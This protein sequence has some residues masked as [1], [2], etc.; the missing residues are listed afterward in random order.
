MATQ[1]QSAWML[2]DLVIED[3]RLAIPESAAN[4]LGAHS[5]VRHE[6]MVAATTEP[7]LATSADLA[8]APSGSATATWYPSGRITADEVPRMKGS[9]R[10]WL[11]A[12]ACLLVAAL[13]VLAYQFDSRREQAA[14]RQDTGPSV[15]ATPDPL[16]H[17]VAS[18]KALAA[19]GATGQAPPVN[20]RGDAAGERS[21]ANGGDATGGNNAL[22]ARHRS[23]RSGCAARS[24]QE[25]ENSMR[26]GFALMALVALLAGGSAAA[27]DADDDAYKIVTAS[28][29]GTYIKIGHDLGQFVAPAANIK[30]VDASFGRLVGECSPSA[31]RAAGQTR[32]RPVGRLSGFP[33]PRGERQRGSR[34]LDPAA[35]GD[36]AALQRGDLFHRA[37]QLAAQLRTRD[38]GRKDQRRRTRQRYGA[39]LGDPLPPDVR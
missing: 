37:R 30:L 14:G 39:D 5:G 27:A 32:A 1:G 38:Q 9:R 35:A 16:V 28:E 24:N 4:L 29:R 18:S 10:V 23:S 7:A 31:P 22:T 11:F 36:R 20:G 33:R 8:R 21:P 12:S 3:G 6:V 25:E 13:A 34:P 15:S 19:L 26:R 17:P 2:N